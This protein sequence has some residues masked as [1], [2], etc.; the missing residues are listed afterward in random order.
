MNVELKDEERTKTEVWTRVM[1]AWGSPYKIISNSN[2][3]PFIGN[4]EES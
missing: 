2:R 4:D 1:G 3:K